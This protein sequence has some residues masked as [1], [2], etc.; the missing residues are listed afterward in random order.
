MR[1]FYVQLITECR[2]VT[3]MGK[4]QIWGF[5]HEKK[6]HLLAKLQNCSKF[7]SFSNCLVTHIWCYLHGSQLLFI[8]DATLVWMGVI[9]PNPTEPNQT[10]PYLTKPNLT[11]TTQ[12]M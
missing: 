12:S 8:E 3:L 10:K 5:G 4:L 7:F 9:K 2:L 11:K 6:I 1:Q